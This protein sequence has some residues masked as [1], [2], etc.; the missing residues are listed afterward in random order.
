MCTTLFAG[1]VKGVGGAGGDALC[2]TLYAEGCGG[3]VQFR[4][5]EI[6]IVAIFSLQF[7]TGLLRFA[8]NAVTQGQSF[9][10]RRAFGPLCLHLSRHSP[11]SL[12]QRLGLESSVPAVLL[13]SENHLVPP[14]LQS[15]S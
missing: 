10:P 6:S 9:T 8:S 3:W 12:Q 14:I 7:A 4:R 11:S 2:A 5:F 13:Q 15:S 1:V